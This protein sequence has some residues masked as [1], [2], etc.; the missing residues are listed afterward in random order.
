MIKE[1]KSLLLLDKRMA[2]EISS[3]HILIKNHSRWKTLQRR[4]VRCFSQMERI[5]YSH[6]EEMNTWICDT[7]EVAIF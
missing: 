7:T 1:R 5:V 3:L 2:V 4:H 6:L